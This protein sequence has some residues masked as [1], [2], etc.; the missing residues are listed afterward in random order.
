MWA[1]VFTELRSFVD[2]VVLSLAA[3]FRC[4][5][6]CCRFGKDSALL[7]HDNRFYRHLHTCRPFGRPFHRSLMLWSIHPSRILTK[8]VM[9]FTMERTRSYHFSLNMFASATFSMPPDIVFFCSRP[10]S[11]GATRPS[12][13]I[14]LFLTAVSMLSLPRRSLGR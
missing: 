12:K 14:R 7:R 4:L 8:F 6:C 5:S 11:M 10:V 3:A 9:S 2:C 1:P 13:S